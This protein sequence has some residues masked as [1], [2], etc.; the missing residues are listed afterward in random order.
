MHMHSECE[1]RG[2]R[3]CVYA[4]L[5]ISFCYMRKRMSK[6]SYSYACEAR[7]AVVNM[8]CIGD[9]WRLCATLVAMQSDTEGR[10]HD[11]KGHFLIRSR[12]QL[13]AQCCLPMP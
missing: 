4:Y 3:L 6:W 8:S 5:C 11:A 9:R 1:C 10:H 2:R 12:R 7:L 13:Q